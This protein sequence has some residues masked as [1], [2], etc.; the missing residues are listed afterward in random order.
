MNLLLKGHFLEDIHFRHKSIHS[1][2]TLLMA[3]GQ[4]LVLSR[5][6]LEASSDLL[7]IRELV[8]ILILDVFQEVFEP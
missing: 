8:D 1:P 5:E 7:D 3:S 2:S 4:V 6:D